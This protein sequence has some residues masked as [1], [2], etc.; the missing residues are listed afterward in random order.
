MLPF[1]DKSFGIVGL[2]D[3]L[4]HFGEDRTILSEAVRVAKPGGIMAITVPAGEELWSNFD[5][6]SHHKRRYTRESISQLM[7]D[8]GIEILTIEFMFMGLYIPMK[9]ARGKESDK[10]NVFAINSI[11]NVISRGFFEIERLISGK[12]P[13]PTGTS[14]IGIGKKPERAA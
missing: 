7:G 13:L 5:V 8:C 10:K 12:M 4:E 2:F 1:S 6:L 14:L 11:A 9:L 3:V